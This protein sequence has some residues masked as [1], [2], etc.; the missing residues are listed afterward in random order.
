MKKIIAT[1]FLAYLIF[2][3]LSFADEAGERMDEFKQKLAQRIDNE[4]QVLVQFKTCIQAAQKRSDFD[5]CRTAKNEA[6]KK[7]MVEMKKDL[8]D[9]RKKQL[10]QEEKQLNES[11]KKQ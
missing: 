4:I 9:N 7:N 10:I 5:A 2:P 1:L 3:S 8:L 6:Q 11:A